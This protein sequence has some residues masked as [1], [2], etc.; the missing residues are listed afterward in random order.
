VFP[1]ALNKCREAT[2]KWGGGKFLVHVST[3]AGEEEN[4]QTY[5]VF[6][7]SFWSIQGGVSAGAGGKKRNIYRFSSHLFPFADMGRGRE[8]DGR[9]ERTGREAMVAKEQDIT[10]VSLPTTN[11][12]NFNKQQRDLQC[13]LLFL[14]GIRIHRDGPSSCKFVLLLLLL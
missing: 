13:D 10:Q 4:E 1:F 9:E 6:A 3:G 2:K 5:R 7:C 8:G 14:L 12:Q 11:Q